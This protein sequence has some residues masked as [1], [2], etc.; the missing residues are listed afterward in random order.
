[1]NEGFRGL[2]SRFVIFIIIEIGFWCGPVGLRGIK[3]PLSLV[4]L[5]IR[6]LLIRFSVISV[7]L[8]LSIT[9]FVV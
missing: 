2:L 7:L 1:M 6:F 4:I 9:C 3:G 5:V 8:I